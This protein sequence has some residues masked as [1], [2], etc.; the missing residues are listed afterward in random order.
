ME[1]TKL[2]QS[3]AALAVAMRQRLVSFFSHHVNQQ[4]VE[5]CAQ[6]TLLAFLTPRRS[7]PAR[8]PIENP[9]AFLW[10]IAHNVAA[11][12]YADRRRPEQQFSDSE[13]EAKLVEYPRVEDVL[14]AQRLVRILETDHRYEEL[15]LSADGDQLFDLANRRGCKP[16][17]MKVELSRMRSRFRAQHDQALLELHVM[18]RSS[19]HHRVLPPGAT[20][21]RG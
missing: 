11:R 16:N 14:Q 19:H 8:R 15:L 13:V 2:P 1:G 7:H 9:E 6:R 5:D 10:G 21:A 4:D 12:H 17:S 18:P 3:F 20:V